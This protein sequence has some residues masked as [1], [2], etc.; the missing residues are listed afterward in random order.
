V[1]LA[2]PLGLVVVGA[3][4][5]GTVAVADQVLDISSELDPVRKQNDVPGL[6]GAT[7]TSRGLEAIGATG[8]R[9]LGAP[10]KVT[11]TDHKAMTATLL[12]IFVEQG[13]LSWKDTLEKLLPDLTSTM[14]PAYRQVTLEQLLAHRAGLSDAT[15]PKGIS[16]LQLRQ[17]SGSL[18]EQRRRYAAAVLAEP[19]VNQPGSRFLYSNRNYIIAGAIA[20]RVGNDSWDN[21]MGSRLFKPLHMDSC[22]FGAPGTPGQIDQ[23]WQHVVTGPL[24]TPLPP[25]PLA[26]N[27]PLI[28]PAGTVH[29]S[30]GDWAK[31]AQAHLRGEK[32][33]TGGI[34]TPETFRYLHTP[35]MD[36]KYAFGWLIE[37][38]PWGGG[39]V[40]T[41]AGSNTMSFAVIWIAP[42]KDFAVLVATN[43]GGEAAAKACDDAATALIRKHTGTAPGNNHG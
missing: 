8:V 38:R 29:C 17:W 40:L 1:K 24:R 41:H 32:G 21:L 43:Q 34:L 13:K 19:P 39:R 9:T 28:G 26:D 20:E 33:D 30:I 3:C 22:G 4:V 15:A 36:G 16:L 12:A 27:P 23:P 14:N 10:D 31:F 2:L 6:V 11:V 42:I 37:N 18:P 35:I 25:G 7:V 5:L